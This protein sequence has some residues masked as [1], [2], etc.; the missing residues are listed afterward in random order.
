MVK[1]FGDEQFAGCTG[2]PADSHSVKWLRVHSST[3][4]HFKTYYISK[5][6]DPLIDVGHR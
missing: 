4:L 3:R 1:S 2:C 6:L 5:V